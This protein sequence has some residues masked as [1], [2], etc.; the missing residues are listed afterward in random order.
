MHC[1][2]LRPGD[3]NFNQ[4]HAVI[5][6]QVWDA[7]YIEVAEEINESKLRF[8]HT[9]AK[10]I[11][12]RISASGLSRHQMVLLAEL[13]PDLSGTIRKA[14]LK[15]DDLHGVLP[16]VWEQGCPPGRDDLH[17]SAGN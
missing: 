2:H 7:I 11:Y 13:Y 17:V 15:G 3:L 10:E 12:S 9:K 4:A 5:A 8:L 16:F 1:V 6:S 14:F